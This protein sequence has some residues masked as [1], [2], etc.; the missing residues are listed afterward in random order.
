MN[1]NIYDARLQHHLRK[2][3]G[4]LPYNQQLQLKGLKL[5]NTVVS[6]K[7]S[8]VFLLRNSA[9]EATFHGQVSCKN[10]WACP[11]C[12]SIIMKNYAKE[13]GAAIDA[14]KDKYF[15]FMV[16][17]TIPH[18]VNQS[19]RDVTD[20]LYK[21]WRVAFAN[22]FSKRSTVSG[23]I[24][25]SS[26]INKFCVD[27]DIVHYVR[28]AE[29]TWSKKNGWHPHFHCIFWT[30]RK[31][32]DNI[33]K[34]EESI[35]DYWMSSFDKVI[36][37]TDY[38]ESYKKYLKT[39][40]YANELRGGDSNGLWISKKDEKIAESLSSEYL[41]G[42]GADSELTGNFKKSASHNG[43]LTPYQILEQAANGDNFM[44]DLY[45][46]FALQ[47][48]RKPVHH[49]VNFDKKGLKKIIKD[50]INKVGYQEFLAK[51]NATWEVVA[52]FTSEQWRKLCEL[53]KNSP[54]LSN[55]LWITANK[56]ELLEDFLESFEIKLAKCVHPL[57]A[58]VENMYNKVTETA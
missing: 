32:K 11:H 15:G 8:T 19:C 23:A 58:N 14:L 50:Y 43:H 54:I 52:F 28:C 30:P 27:N 5:C 45:I 42:W 36:D 51:K 33:L 1:Q 35:R 31:N 22:A 48:T 4:T 56:K 17:L 21:T 38:K 7:F 46:E 6:P 18:D 47:V 29:Y 9:G 39:I 55:I 3:I 12:S 57:A 13:I 40:N 34:Y 53:D 2:K 44:S 16:T 20:I 25:Y 10:P 41:A 26:P 37:K 24:R 49:R